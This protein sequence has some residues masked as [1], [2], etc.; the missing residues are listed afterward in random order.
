LLKLDKEAHNLMVSSATNWLW[1]WL[2]QLKSFGHC[3]KQL[4]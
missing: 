1:P 3:L 4:I 2:K